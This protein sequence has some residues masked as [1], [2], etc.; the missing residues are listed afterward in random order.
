VTFLFGG[1]TTRAGGLLRA[2]GQVLQEKKKKYNF[3][4]GTDRFAV[5]HPCLSFFA[6]STVTNSKPC[7]CTVSV[8]LFFFFF[9]FFCCKNS[10][11]T[12]HR[13][14]SSPLLIKRCMWGK[15][16]EPGE[17]KRDVNGVGSGA[18]F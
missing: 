12:K 3:A 14:L 18:H 2:C 6:T 13:T 16:E 9:F 15:V 7:A 5:G 11:P 17:K 8:L 4:K 1:E 10:V